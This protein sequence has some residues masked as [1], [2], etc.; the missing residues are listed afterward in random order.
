MEE[1]AKT[2]RKKWLLLIVTL[3]L[4]CARLQLP[5]IGG[6]SMGKRK[7][8]DRH[9]LAAAEMLE[10]DYFKNDVTHGTKTFRGC[11]RVNK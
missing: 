4:L 5:R 1:E 3:L 11:F 6:S 9:R 2:E 10:D 7:S 8:I